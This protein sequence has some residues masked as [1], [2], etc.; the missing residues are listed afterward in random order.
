ME[1]NLFTVI[2][3]Y[4]VQNDLK[5]ENLILPK[6]FF[7]TEEIINGKFYTAYKL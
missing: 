4:K 1:F 3:F 7:C 5:Q 2:I 6:I